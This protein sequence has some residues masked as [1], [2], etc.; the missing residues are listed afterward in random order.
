MLLKITENET[1]VLILPTILFAK[2]LILRVIQ[3]DIVIN[4]KTFLFEVHFIFV[5]F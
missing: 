1:C 5:G 3:R 4:A 2:L